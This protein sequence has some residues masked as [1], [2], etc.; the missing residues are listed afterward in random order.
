MGLRQDRL[1]DEIRDLLA[2]T[3]SGDKIQDPRL[4]LLTITAVKLSGDLQI[5]NVYY[6]VMNET[7]AKEVEGGLASASGFLRR[8]IASNLDVRRVP[9]LRFFY[10]KSVETGERIEELL[11]KIRS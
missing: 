2:S 3:F 7:P 9:D 1:G 6:R 4:K 8:I 10:D 11:E 5:A